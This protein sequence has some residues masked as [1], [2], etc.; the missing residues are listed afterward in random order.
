MGENGEL[1]KEEEEARDELRF[2]TKVVDEEVE[3]GREREAGCSFP[4]RETIKTSC[5]ETKPEEKQTFVFHALKKRMRQIRVS[6]HM[7]VQET[8]PP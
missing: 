2:H 3:P 8:F 4:G 7:R 5:C 1:G 6:Q